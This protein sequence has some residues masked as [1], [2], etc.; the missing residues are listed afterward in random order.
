VRLPDLLQIGGIN[1]KL[2][3]ESSFK[4]KIKNQK[5]KPKIKNEEIDRRKAMLKNILGFWF[6]ILIFDF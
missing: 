6:V 5:H 2:H 3:L 1:E 4:S